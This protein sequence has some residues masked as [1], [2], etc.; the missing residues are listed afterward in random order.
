VPPR[1][2][3]DLLDSAL[4]SLLA[5]RASHETPSVRCPCRCHGR[6]PVPLDS[7]R[8][9][10][11]RAGRAARS[12]GWSGSGV[13]TLTSSS[14]AG[15]RR[16]TTSSA[17]TRAGWPVGSDRLPRPTRS[18]TPSSG[19][20]PTPD[21]PAEEQAFA[22]AEGLGEACKATR[23]RCSGTCRRRGGQGHG[24][25]ASALGEAKLTYLGKSYGTYL[26]AIYA[27]LFPEQVGRMVLDGASPRTS[28]LRRSTSAR[29]R[30][31]R[32]PPARGQRTASR[33]GTARSGRSVDEVMEGLRAFLRAGQQPL[34]VRATTPSRS[35]PRAGPPGRGAAMYDQ[36]MWEPSLSRPVEGQGRRHL[37][38]GP[39]RTSTPTA[40]RGHLR[41]QHHGGHLRGQLPGQARHRRSPVAEERRWPSAPRRPTWGPFLAWGSSALRGSGRS[42][43]PAS[44]R[45]EDRGARGAPPIVVIGTTRDPA[46][47]Y[48][49]AAT[50]CRSA[51]RNS[52]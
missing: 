36:G 37:A 19:Q 30:A 26:G 3:R 50:A 41:R 38:H 16:P 25:P 2:D 4:G 8:W 44:R 43:P 40:T 20:D 24:H 14:A 23:G 10:S 33:R 29:P 46:T 6:R 15:A 32:R 52:C 22:T 47:P 11:T 42:P 48:E 51:R 7:G 27:G 39:R 45:A 34:P 9:S 12:S 1:P 35:S 21:D 5:Y 31:S 18:S 49:W 13:A 17:S 28:R